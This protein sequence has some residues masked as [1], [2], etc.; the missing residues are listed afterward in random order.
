MR[1]GAMADSIQIA[2][3]VFPTEI[4]ANDFNRDGISDIALVNTKSQSLSLYFGQKAAAPSGPFSYSLTDEPSHLA[5]HSSTDTTLQLVLSFPQ[6]HQI[7][8]FTT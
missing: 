6:S 4:I 8:Y 3:G 7:S 5:F 1:S 2:T